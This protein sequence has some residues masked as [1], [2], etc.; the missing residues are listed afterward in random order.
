MFASLLLGT[1]VLTI[2]A[3]WSLRLV[4][5]GVFFWSFDTLNLSFYTILSILM[6]FVARR[7]S[8][9]QN[10]YKFSRAF[11][12]FSF[13]KIL[14]SIFIIVAFIEITGVGQRHFLA[15]FIVT[16]VLFTVMETYVFLKLSKPDIEAQELHH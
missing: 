10:P 7:A 3:L 6:Y 14:V 5:A 8:R 16:Y 1:L 15:S 12:M 2:A 11:L 4:M 13:I 9:D